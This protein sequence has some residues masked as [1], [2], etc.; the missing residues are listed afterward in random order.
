MFLETLLVKFEMKIFK[1]FNVSPNIR[2][3][4]GWRFSFHFFVWLR[5]YFN[6]KSVLNSLWI[7]DNK[8][9]QV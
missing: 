2:N 7:Y 3:F 9:N 6:Y 5:K 8:L 1:V 4:G